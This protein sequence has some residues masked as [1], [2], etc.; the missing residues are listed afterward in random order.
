MQ[1]KKKMAIYKSRHRGCK[2]NDVLLSKITTDDINQMNETEVNLFLD[3]LEKDDS[4]IYSWI[5]TQSTPE[6]YQFIASKIENK[7]K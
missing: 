7:Q 6:M 4:Q 5:S 1:T 2:E 3:F